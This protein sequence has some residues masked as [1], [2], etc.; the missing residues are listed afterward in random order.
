M[1][2]C[3]TVLITILKYQYYNMCIGYIGKITWMERVTV[4]V[5]NAYSSLKLN[6]RFG[7]LLCFSVHSNQIKSKQF[8]RKGI[9]KKEYSTKL[10][11]YR[12]IVNYVKQTS[13]Q[14]RLRLTWL[15]CRMTDEATQEVIIYTEHTALLPWWKFT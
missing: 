10:W 2:N 6:H 12:V 3:K 5:Y 11:R 1:Y 14:R 15:H 9:I 13:Y 7:F 4:Q 8:I